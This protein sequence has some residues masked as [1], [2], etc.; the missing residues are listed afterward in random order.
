MV[1][2]EDWTSDDRD[3]LQDEIHQSDGV[4]VNDNRTRTIVMILNKVSL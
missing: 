3:A 1:F 2:V 4:E